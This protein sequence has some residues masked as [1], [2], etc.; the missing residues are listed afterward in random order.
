MAN[1]SG[2]MQFPIRKSLSAPFTGS[3]RME[4]FACVFEYATAGAIA[5]ALRIAWL[6]FHCSRIGK[7]NRR[8]SKTY[9]NQNLRTGSPIPPAR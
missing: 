2:A 3:A 4:L 5:T 9:I 6:A 8:G 1:A 7:A